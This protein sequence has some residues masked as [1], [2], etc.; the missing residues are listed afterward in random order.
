MLDVVVVVG[1]ADHQARGL[2]EV[3][4]EATQVIEHGAIL[5]YASG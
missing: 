1:H 3:F 4:T 5:N 2:T